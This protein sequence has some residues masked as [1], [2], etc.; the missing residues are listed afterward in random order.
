MDWF[1]LFIHVILH[2]QG[3]KVFYHKVIIETPT[4]K[5]FVSV[6][7]LTSVPYNLTKTPH[8]LTRRDVLPVGFEE[9]M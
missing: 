9:P 1:F 6:K 8:N 3:K 7:C 5:E 2:F 4:N